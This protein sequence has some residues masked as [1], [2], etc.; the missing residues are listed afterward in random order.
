MN[1][2]HLVP[3]AEPVPAEWGWFKLFLILGFAV[4]ILLV[5]IVIGVSV[6]SLFASFGR[7]KTLAPVRR[8]LDQKLTVVFALAVNF[9]VLP[10][11]F[12]QV[13]YGQ[14]VYVSSQLMA[15]YWLSAVLLALIAYYLLYWSKFGKDTPDAV[16][17]AAKGLTVLL[18]LTVAFLFSNN[19]TLMLR[20]ETWAAFFTPSD[21]TLLNLSDPV[22]LPRFLHFVI[23][24]VAV[25]GLFIAIVQTLKGEKGKEA[26]AGA[27]ALGMKYLTFA[28]LLQIPAGF[29]FQMRLPRDIMHLFLGGSLPHTAVFLF[30]LLLIIQTLYFGLKKAVWAAAGSM[31][32]LVFAMINMRDMVRTAYLNPFFRIQSLE[33]T[34]QYSAF[35]FFAFSLF[36]S[37][38]LIW[39]VTELARKTL[40]S[41]P[42]RSGI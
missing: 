32:V 20:P 23:A 10:F 19:M 8:D 38:G 34:G 42:E 6:I 13:L 39:Y 3:L 17:N 41:K 36:V 27:I 14:F 4:H 33:N 40:Q 25:G 11:L 22:L 9:G 29:W 2:L 26:D 15:V 21:G 7:K 35:L 31:L 5:N 30:S 12:L 28:T 1:P 37:A 16:G 18:L 24:S